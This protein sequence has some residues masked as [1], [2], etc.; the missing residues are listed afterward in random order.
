MAF[1]APVDVAVVTVAKAPTS[2]PGE[3][4]CFHVA[5]GLR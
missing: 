2:N 4:L 5:T 3:S 1:T